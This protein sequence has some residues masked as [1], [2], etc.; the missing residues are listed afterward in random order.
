MKRTNPKEI[1]I[2]TIV[3][4][5]PKGCH[6]YRQSFEEI[7]DDGN[8]HKEKLVALKDMAVNQKI[9]ISSL[10][11][12]K[13]ELLD[14]IDQLELKE[15]NANDMISRMSKETKK[16]KIQI[17]ELRKDAIER[18]EEFNEISKHVMNSKDLKSKVKDLEDE[19]EEKDEEIL[20]IKQLGEGQSQ[21]EVRSF[22]LKEELENCV[23]DE[24]TEEIQHETK[25]LK[26][27][28]SHLKGN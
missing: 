17:R 22:I 21:A 3:Y 25:I 26:D 2:E 24:K 28:L 5:C 6:R 20:H 13:D 1:I 12:Y 9:I 11:K 16:L 4:A 27:E 15:Q 8:K 10:R 23:V 14:N 18:E 7:V 19:I